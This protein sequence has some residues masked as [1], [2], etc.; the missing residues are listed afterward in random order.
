MA[1]VEILNLLNKAFLHEL[2]ATLVY[3]RNA[4][5]ISECKPARITEWI[6]IDEMRHMNWL[7]ELIVKRGGKPSMEHKQLHFGEEN[8]EGYLKR[9][10][11]LENEAIE[12]YKSAIETIKDE[13]VIGI[14]KHILD[15]EKRHR[16][17]F[18]IQLEAL[19]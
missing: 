14:L 15:E 11:E 16:K 9:Q 7:A 5:L 3:A 17:E 10:I 2:E 8:L 19:K 12:L 18:K 1:T 6:A 4:F 13:E